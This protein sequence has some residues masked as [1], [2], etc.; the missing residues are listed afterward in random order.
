MGSDWGTW[1]HCG[2][3]R[4]GEETSGDSKQACGLGARE[5]TSLA[6]PCHSFCPVP[7]AKSVPLSG[8]SSS[9]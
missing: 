7:P 8:V 5:L 9:V 1:R 6:Q 4:K 3:R 2:E